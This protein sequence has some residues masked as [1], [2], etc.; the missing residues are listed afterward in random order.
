MNDK[1]WAGLTFES[2]NH[3]SPEWKNNSY[4]ALKNFLSSYWIIDES[5]YSDFNWEKRIIRMSEVYLLKTDNFRYA[6]SNVENFMNIESGTVIWYDGE[7]AVSYN[8]DIC[9]VMPTEKNF[10][11]WEEAFFVGEIQE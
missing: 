7:E 10:K 2:G 11:I 5:F 4:R 1:W 3:L 9:L 8:R 6:I